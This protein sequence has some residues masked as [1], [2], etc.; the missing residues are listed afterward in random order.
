M[1][2]DI[3]QSDSTFQNIHGSFINVV[4]QAITD[5]VFLFY[6][7]HLKKQTN[8]QNITLGRMNT[9]WNDSVFFTSLTAFSKQF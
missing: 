9:I 2:R 3:F 1:I 7:K 6:R 8:K 4:D 5:N